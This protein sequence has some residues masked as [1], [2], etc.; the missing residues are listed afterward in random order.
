MAR[1]GGEGEVAGQLDELLV[2][3]QGAAGQ[4]HGSGHTGQVVVEEGTAAQE[5]QR[6]HH[7]LKIDERGRWDMDRIH[8]V[9]IYL[10]YHSVQYVPSSELGTKGGWGHTRQRVGGGG[11][12]S[13]NADDWRKSLSLCQLLVKK[14]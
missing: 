2:R 7:D 3:G 14:I 11:W 13:S 4:L 1:G 12:G 5:P 6:L 9:H 8:K 10:E